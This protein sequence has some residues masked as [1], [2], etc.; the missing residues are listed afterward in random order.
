MLQNGGEFRGVRVLKPASV[1]L[2]LTLAWTYDRRT[3]NGNTWD[4]AASGA[5]GC[6]C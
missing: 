3:R 4:F 6:T 2:M 1:E 5:S